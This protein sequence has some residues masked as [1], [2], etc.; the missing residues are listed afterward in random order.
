MA[1]QGFLGNRKKRGNMVL[2]QYVLI[3]LFLIVLLSGCAT[4]TTFRVL[5]AETKKP[6]EGAVALTEWTGSR[7]VPG[8]SYTVTTKVAEDVSDSEGKLTIPGTTGFN[9]L[10]R[11]HIK[12]YKPG[13]VGWNSSLIYL[14]CYKNDRTMQRIERRKDFSM[15]NQD[16]FLV[17][18]DKEEHSYISHGS[19]IR[20]TADFLEAGTRSDDSKY[21]KAIEYELP[22]KRR[23]KR[24]LRETQ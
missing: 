4:S 18:W 23:E 21:R 3:P 19:F 10:Q 14:G 17:P 15:K 24:E 16:I 1:N 11:P 22:F 13:Y 2:K 8:L 5:D 7:G 9:A 20:T 12:V 6:I